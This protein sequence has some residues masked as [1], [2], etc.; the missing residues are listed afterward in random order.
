[1]SLKV[2][3]GFVIYQ[4]KREYYGLVIN[5]TDDAVE[6]VSVR[7]VNDGVQPTVKCYDDMGAVYPKDKDNVR[8]TSCPPP[9]SN[10]CGG[11]SKDCCISDA[12]AVADMD[13]VHS[14]SKMC[15]ETLCDIIDNGVCISDKD[16]ETVRHHHME[17]PL[18]KEKTYREIPE[19]RQIESD[20][21]DLDFLQ[22]PR[23]QVKSAEQES[24]SNDIMKQKG[25]DSQCQL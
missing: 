16:M 1:M 7:A 17:N 15:F 10:V 25:D 14:V 21:Y 12:Y 20:E 4:Q 8:L 22:R 18:Q 13:H 2:G 6:Y 3:Q 5:V 19:I 23:N 9:F 11:V 24:V